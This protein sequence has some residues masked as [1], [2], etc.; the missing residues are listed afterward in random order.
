MNPPVSTGSFVTLFG[1]APLASRTFITRLCAR[2]LVVQSAPCKGVSPVSG[3]G[4]FHIGPALNKKLA[5]SPVPAKSCSIQIQVVSQ[6]FERRS[7]GQ[8]EFD[9]AHIA[10]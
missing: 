8:Q 10:E 4:Q 5:Q 6:R 7:V 1:F 9:G 3:N 2:R